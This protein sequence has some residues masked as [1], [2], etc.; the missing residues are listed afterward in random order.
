[1]V[2]FLLELGVRFFANKRFC[3]LLKQI[4]GNKEL[5]RS[6]LLRDAWT[7][8]GKLAWSAVRSVFLVFW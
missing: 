2:D 7:V 3:F 6:S 4:Q 5:L 8:G 1:M